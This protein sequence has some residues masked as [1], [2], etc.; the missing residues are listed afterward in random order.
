MGNPLFV[1]L[2]PLALAVPLVACGSS[3][4][5]DPNGDGGG[6]TGGTGTGGTG[7]GGGTGGTIDP[8]NP[9]PTAQ[10]DKVDL[11]LAIDNSRSMADKQAILS[12]GVPDLVSFFT[13][14]SCVDPQSGEV[15]SQ[16][17][18]PG[19]P[20]VAGS[21]RRFAPVRDLH[22]G[23]I[24]SSLGGHGADAC[25]GSTIISENDE[26]HLLVRSEPNGG[27]P[28]PTY[29]GLGFLAWDPDGQLQ[30]PG[31]SDEQTLITDLQTMIG[32]VGEIGCGYE[33]QLES[34]Y[35]FLIDPDPHDTIDIVD[36]SAV[37]SGTDGELLTQR[38]DFMRPDSVLVVLMT[39]DEND[40]STRDGGQFYFANQIYQPGSSNPYH[41]P[42]PR[43]ACATDPNSPCCRSCGQAPGDGC[44]DSQDDC[45]G[46][47]SSL[48]DSINLRCFD[49]KR[50]FG[51]D[52]LYPIDRYVTGLTA[53]HVTDRHGNVVPNPLY[54]DPNGREPG[55][56]Y[57]GALV[58][59]PWQDIARQDGSGV[60]DLMAGLSNGHPVGGLQNACELQQNGVWD[61]ILGNLGQNVAP[62]DPLM[63]ESVEPRTGVN[64]ITGGALASPDSGPMAN[65]INGHERSIPQRDD[66]QYACIFPLAQPRDCTDPNQIACECND[67]NSDNPLCQDGSGQYGTTQ[68]YA[69]AYPGRRHLAVLAGLGAQGVV[70]SICPAQ[71]G[72][73][74]QTDWG[75]RPAFAAIAEAATR[76]LVPAQ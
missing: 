7:L 9:T 38:D 12:L 20:C 32:G 52:F 21:Q 53:M 31:Q 5:T 46:S 47:L 19:V 40:C 48:D 75:Y 33:S 11:L 55:M 16:P 68:Y 28:V 35:R 34:W 17:S 41:L 72:S 29:L 62:T 57:F 25:A 71:M 4:V 60:P 66:L 2:L 27:V 36:A 50:R 64:P 63:V 42:K 10:T 22:I 45:S 65:P 39:T 74:S 70:G 14:P 56:A 13:N 15:V 73:P 3:V 30:P 67:P 54:A 6:G 59:V 44:D 24:S 58:G 8:C 18:S 51:I 49:Q 23:I 43:A 69:K 26:G 61:V 37:L 76:S 1:S